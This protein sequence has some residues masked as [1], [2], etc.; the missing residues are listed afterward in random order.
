MLFMIV[1]DFTKSDI[2]DI[3]RHLR[4]RGRG[5]PAGLTYHASWISA[6]LTTCYQLME[7]DDASLLQ[8][9]TMHWRN[10]A[11]ITIV[12]VT[13]SKEVQRVVG[14]YLDAP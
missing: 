13:A 1:E 2:A 5:I 14:P 7:T 9:W 11:G 12:P 10:L 8:R 6:D 4:D 3:Y